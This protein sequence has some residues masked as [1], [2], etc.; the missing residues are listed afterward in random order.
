MG[1]VDLGK[2]A[3]LLKKG[4][5]HWLQN[6]PPLGSWLALSA[7]RIVEMLQTATVQEML[8]HEDRHERL[9]FIDSLACQERGNNHSCL[10]TGEHR[11][12]QN[13]RPGGF[14]LPSPLCR[15]LL[16][17]P[18][19]PLASPLLRKAPP[20]PHQ[21]RARF[22]HRSGARRYGAQRARSHSLE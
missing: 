20:G 11:F 6:H 9:S 7:R 15:G 19:R 16:G 5:A 12:S 18:V 14:F 2:R 22:H 8:V 17:L 13:V 4:A 21:V 3:I 1:Q 10:R